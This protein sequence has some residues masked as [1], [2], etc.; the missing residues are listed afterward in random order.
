MINTE[1]SEQKTRD[2]AERSEQVKRIKPGVSLLFFLHEE[3]LHS[4][5]LVG[6]PE[7]ARCALKFVLSSALLRVLRV[8]Q[9][10]FLPI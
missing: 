4:Q 10:G 3:D 6:P 5:N 8:L 9:A 2:Q 7:F 1:Q